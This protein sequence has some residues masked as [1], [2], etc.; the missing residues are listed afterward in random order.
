MTYEEYVL[1]IPTAAGYLKLLAQQSRRQ[2]RKALVALL[3]NS[4]NTRS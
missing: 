2:L 1:Q 4:Q 3:L